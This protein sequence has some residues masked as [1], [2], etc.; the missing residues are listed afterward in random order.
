[1]SFTKN[2]KLF[3]TEIFKLWGN[4]MELNVPFFKPSFSEEEKNAVCKCIDSGWLTT[5]KETHSFEEEFASYVNSKFALAVNSNTSGMILALE[6]IGVQKGKTVI[7]TPYTFVSTAASAVHLGGEV[8]FADTE[9]NSYSIDPKKIEE[10]LKNDKENKIC[11]IIAVHIAGNLCNMKELKNLAE[12]YSTEKNRIYLIEDCAHSFPSR[13]DE[14]FA[15]TLGDIGIFS[16]YA[17]KTI[18]T[19]EG[20]MITTN[21][22]KL[23]KRMSIMR[24]HGMSR[25]AW[26]RYTNP[27]ASWQYDIVAPGFKSNLPDILSAIGRV[28]LKKAQ[29]FF[30]KRKKIVDFYNNSFKNEDFIILPPDSN[31]NA[32]HLYLLRITPEKLN[33]NRDEYAKLLQEN[34][35]GISVHF[36]PLFYFSYWKEKYP[37]FKETA[38][39]NAKFNFE[40]T[41]SLPLWPDMS[42][43]M[44]QKVVE[45]VIKI[46][47]EHYVR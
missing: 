19:G 29:I 36:I 10:L 6:S 38:F 14:G 39:P 31:G 27:N 30:E 33:I 47:K 7:T 45:T 8:L 21:D 16:F 40:R 15:G 44:A 43:E 25:D 13:T 24:L 46:G 32:W 37:E 9:K 20:G 22:E 26:D 4:F 1:M 35:I 17:T 2:Q 41:I 23:A 42:E 12:K 34:G 5:G 18:T 28:Q 3:Q 11:A